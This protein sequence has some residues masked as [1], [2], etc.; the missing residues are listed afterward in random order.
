[1]GAALR[2][3]AMSGRVGSVLLRALI[4]GFAASAVLALMPLV[5]LHTVPGG[6][7]TYGLLLGALGP[8]AVGGAVATAMLR[9]SPTNGTQVR[10]SLLCLGCATDHLRPPP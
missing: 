2:Y 3:A 6:P 8:G 4:F 5:A 10:W 7:L 1:M 9:P